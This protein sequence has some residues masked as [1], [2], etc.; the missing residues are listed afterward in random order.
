VLWLTFNR[1]QSRNAMTFEMYDR[2]GAIA[3]EANSDDALRCIVLTGA[4][5]KAFVAGTDIGQFREF[6]TEEDAVAYE[7]R[8]ER[9]IGSLAQVRIPTI[10]AVRGACTGGGFAIAAACDIRVGSPSARFG[11]PI[12]RTLGNCLSMASLNLLVDLLGPARAKEMLFTARLIEAPE[13]REIG[14]VN[15]LVD[16]EESLIPRVESLAEQIAGNAPLTIRAVKEGIRR[17]LAGRHID[18]REGRDLIVACYLSEDFREGM[19]A[20]LEKRKPNWQGR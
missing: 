5:E 17:I 19:S 15:E 10:A 12:A 2:L 11:I 13:A 18:P 9:E 3:R 1:P 20:F 6:R 7:E 14:L 4:G 8:M 16:S